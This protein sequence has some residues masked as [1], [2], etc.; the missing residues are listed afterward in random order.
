MSTWTLRD[1]YFGHFR[2]WS[3]QPAL[4]LQTTLRRSR[5]LRVGLRAFI[6]FR[7]WGLGFRFWGLGFRFGGLGISLSP[8]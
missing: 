8:S 6:G 3:R 4:Q 7:V 2:K 5:S 1:R